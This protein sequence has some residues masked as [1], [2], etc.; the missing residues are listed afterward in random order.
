MRELPGRHRCAHI[1][2]SHFLLYQASLKARVLMVL[3]TDNLLTRKNTLLTEVRKR[4]KFLGSFPLL[5]TTLL[6]TYGHHANESTGHATR[7]KSNLI[8][9]KEMWTKKQPAVGTDRTW[10]LRITRSTNWKRRLTHS[11]LNAHIYHIKW[12]RGGTVRGSHRGSSV[13]IEHR[14]RN[15]KVAGPVP[16]QGKPSLRAHFLLHKTL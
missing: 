3:C 12:T 11:R 15:S 14:A 2:F 6:R 5:D 1:R 16:V 7:S 10:D 4:C 8:V 13:G 9:K